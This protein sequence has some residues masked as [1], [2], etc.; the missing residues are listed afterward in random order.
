MN[1]PD[2]KAGI[3][4]GGW[5]NI[6]TANALE[7]TS[8]CSVLDAGGRGKWGIVESGMVVGVLMGGCVGGW[9]GVQIGIREY[10]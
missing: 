2:S 9:V 3:F 8:Y 7:K 10:D 4:F 5:V 6:M 1:P